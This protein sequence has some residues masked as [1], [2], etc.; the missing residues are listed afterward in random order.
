MTRGLC[1]K[2]IEHID[3]RPCHHN[4][5][6]RWFLVIS[7]CRAEPRLDPSL[8]Y[9]ATSTASGVI[10]FAK[11]VWLGVTRTTTPGLLC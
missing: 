8:L 9:L 1:S 3:V 10:L 2:T 11:V 7:L 4:V 5:T 6:S